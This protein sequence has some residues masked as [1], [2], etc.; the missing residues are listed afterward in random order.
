MRR[1]GRERRYFEELILQQE[2]APNHA[3]ETIIFTFSCVN[4]AKS[5]NLHPTP[6]VKKS[7]EFS[8]III[9]C[10]H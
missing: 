4:C 10:V 7:S 6:S 2:E 5:I 8:G 3:S 9:F 1:G